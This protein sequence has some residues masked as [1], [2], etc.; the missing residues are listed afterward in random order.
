MNCPEQGRILLYLEGE[1][2]PDENQA[3][4]DHLSSCSR[5]LQQLNEVEDNLNFAFQSLGGL[6]EE[7]RQAPPMGQAKVWEKVKNYRRVKIR[8]INMMKMRKAAI[9]AVIVLAIGVVGSMPAVQTAAANL[10]QVFRV[11][12]VD[13]ITLGSNDMTQIQNALQQ[14]NQKIDMENFGSFQTVGEADDRS[15][16]AE[17][18]SD[19]AFKAKLP[20]L[21]EGQNAEYTLQK[22]PTI[23]IKPKV[24]NI[25]KLLLG[26]GSEYKLPAALDGQICRIT[27]EDSLITRYDDLT[28]YQQPSP[29]IEV[30]GGIS[31]EE[32]AR[33][34]VALPIWPENVKTQLQSVTDWEHTL[35][36]PTGETGSKVKVNG[37]N[38][39]LV[40]EKNYRSLIWQDNGILYLLEDH[41]NKQLD[42]VKMAESLR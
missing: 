34:M 14:G 3:I 15:I 12:N 11:Q 21:M 8:G 40:N 18:L 38:G 30:P 2:E 23:E 13:T 17:E 41:S 20:D 10:L 19:L 36:I 31:V 27:M 22:T 16:T 37:N 9:A 32:V 39:V 26:L 5:C 7:Y 42:L 28:L 4:E 33:A 1:L 29:Q 25:N 35:L 24:E 6:L